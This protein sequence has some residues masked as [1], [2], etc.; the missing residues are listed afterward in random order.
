M[1]EIEYNPAKNADV[2]CLRVLEDGSWVGETQRFGTLVS[3][4]EAK[5]EDAL[6]KLLTH[7]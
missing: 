1:E 2:I 7:G 4:R 5:P 3:V 6:V